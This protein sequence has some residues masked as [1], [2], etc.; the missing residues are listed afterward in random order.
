MSRYEG[1]YTF[2]TDSHMY[3][4]VGQVDDD[5]FTYREEDA[6]QPLIRDEKIRKAVRAWIDANDYGKEDIYQFFNYETGWQSWSIEHKD[7]GD[8][9]GIHFNGGID[10]GRAD[11]GSFYTI[12]ELFGEEEE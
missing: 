11:D 6:K 4:P 10:F 2:D 12:G 7:N 3:I 1:L 5:Y 9:N 8:E